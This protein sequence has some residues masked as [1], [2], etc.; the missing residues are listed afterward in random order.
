MCIYFLPKSYF[1][2]FFKKEMVQEVGFEHA[3][4]QL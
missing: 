2:F 1:L 3:I 4:F